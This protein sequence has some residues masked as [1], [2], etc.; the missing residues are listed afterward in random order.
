MDTLNLIYITKI[1]LGVLS[2][3]ICLLFGIDNLSTGIGIAMFVYLVSDWLLKRIFI[4]KVDKPSTITKT[5]IGIYVIT[6]I[7]AWIL[8][9]SLFYTPSA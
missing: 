6:W 3:G 2:A 1:C 5:G 7:L 8:I 4:Q 9:F